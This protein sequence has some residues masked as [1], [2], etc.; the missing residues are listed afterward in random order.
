MAI[1]SMIDR[2]KRKLNLSNRF[3]HDDVSFGLALRTE[4][5]VAALKSSQLLFFH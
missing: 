1:V 5:H 3:N 2:K 4:V